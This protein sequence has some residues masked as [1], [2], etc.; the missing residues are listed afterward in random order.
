PD[1]EPVWPGTWHE[2]AAKMLRVDLAVATRALKKADPKSEGI[3]YK[4]DAGYADFH[5]LRHSYITLLERCGVSPRMAQDLPRH[6][7][8]RLTM[9]VYQHAALYD[10]AAAVGGLPAS[11]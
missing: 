7:S 5:A 10:M 3:P 6:S 8:I 4:N 2:K 9:N 1:G 11:V